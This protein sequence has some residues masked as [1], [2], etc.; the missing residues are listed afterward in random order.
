M[1]TFSDEGTDQLDKNVIKDGN[2]K[3]ETTVVYDTVIPDSLCDRRQMP[4][5]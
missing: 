4:K 1:L 5:N 2:K 3:E